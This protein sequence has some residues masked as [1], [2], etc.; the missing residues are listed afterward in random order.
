MKKTLLSS[1]K[2]AML[3]TPFGRI[4]NLFLEKKI[5]KESMANQNRKIPFDIISR[6]SG[7]KDALKFGEGENA[8]F[9][10]FEP[11]HV[12]LTFGIPVY[13]R[14]IV[15]V[16]RKFRFDPDQSSFLVKHNL[17]G[18]GDIKRNVMKSKIESLVTEEGSEK[19]FCRMIILFMSATIFFPN[20]NN[21]IGKSF[22][23]H[24]ENIENMRKLGRTDLIYSELMKK[25]KIKKE[26]PLYCACVIPLLIKDDFEDIKDGENLL[27]EEVI[28]QPEDDNTKD[29]EQLFK[30]NIDLKAEIVKL[31]RRI[32]ELEIERRIEVGDEERWEDIVED[33]QEE[34]QQKKLMNAYK[35]DTCE[36][37]ARIVEDLM[38]D[39]FTHG[40]IINFYMKR[41]KNNEDPNTALSLYVS[42]YAWT[43]FI[44]KKHK[45]KEM[46]LDAMLQNHFTD[47]IKFV[48]VPMNT[49]KSVG[50]SEGHH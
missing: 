24:L 23:V 29:Y 7:E 20:F 22:V 36:I 28:I 6:Y 37:S 31:K 42:A 49:S 50:Q 21:N 1:H 34:E 43:H 25:V 5:K 47:D 4:F 2:D 30:E 48:F 46:A 44:A 14:K 19:D 12:A 17:Q 39:G 32:D 38:F 9:V 33:G 26:N 16:F 10:K 18:C 3:N 11:K 35:D 8:K 27:L 15:E 40:E 41:L 45:S 13:G